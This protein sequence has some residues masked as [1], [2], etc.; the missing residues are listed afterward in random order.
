MLRSPKQLDGVPTMS[1]TRKTPV[2]V[3]EMSVYD[4]FVANVTS[5][6][7]SDL[8]GKS[9]MVS[10]VYMKKCKERVGKEDGILRVAVAALQTLDD[11]SWALQ[12]L[13]S[14]RVA[15]VPQYDKR[16]FFNSLA[17]GGSIVALVEAMRCGCVMDE[18]E[19]VMAVAKGSLEALKWLYDNGCP[20]SKFRCLEEVAHG[21]QLHIIKWILYTVLVYEPPRGL[22]EMV[23]G[24]AY[25]A[26]HGNQVHVITDHQ[27]SSPK[28]VVITNH[29]LWSTRT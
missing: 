11:V 1:N 9:A 15:D 26:A 28:P 7:P 20:V 19:T 12:T 2:Y 4:F 18:E 25:E 21:G 16:T 5:C 27:L 6:F 14:M 3:S 29:R 17:Y 10:K 13:E 8:I 22:E 23:E 24:L